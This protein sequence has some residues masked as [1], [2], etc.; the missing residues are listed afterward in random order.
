[1]SVDGE[2]GAK[3]LM[4]GIWS[5]MSL[6]YHELFEEIRKCKGSDKCCGDDEPPPNPVVVPCLDKP[7]IMVVT[8]QR[9]H[10]ARNVICPKTLQ[11]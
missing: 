8:E 5:A 9:H 3:S 10:L 7:E 6:K 11:K 4:Y 1:L 2:Y